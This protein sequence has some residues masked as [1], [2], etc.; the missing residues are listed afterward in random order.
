RAAAL[1]GEPEAL[2][3]RER[4]AVER[5]TGGSKR[6]RLVEPQAEHQALGRARRGRQLLVLP[7]R[8]LLRG[9]RGH[10]TAERRRVAPAAV[11]D[12]ADRAD[13]EAE[14]VTPEPVAEV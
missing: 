3:A 12:C 6:K 1:L 5:A 4:V 2:E 9:E 11:L 10:V 8:P 13:A 14:V 7:R